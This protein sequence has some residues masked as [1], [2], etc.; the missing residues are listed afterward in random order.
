MNPDNFKQAWQTQ[1]SQ[2]HLAID[3]ELLLE[4]V[5]RNQRHFIATIFWRDVREIGTSLLMVPLWF[6]LGSKFSLPWSW[7]L[8]VL[9]LMWIAGFMLVDRIRHRQRP[10]EQGQPLRQRLESSLA[11]VDHQIWLLRNVYWWYL[12]PI[13]VSILAFFVHVSWH[14]WSVGWWT[15]LSITVPVLVVA[16]VFAGIY[17]LNQYAVRCYL[18][19]RRQE[20]ETL[21]ISLEDETPAAS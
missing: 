20:L 6:Y 19:P 4:Q 5:Q 7:Y 12:L 9:A 15:A 17:W 11:Q 18:A 2:A 1:S 8:S 21:L 3:A 14:Q 10:L 16:V 13:A